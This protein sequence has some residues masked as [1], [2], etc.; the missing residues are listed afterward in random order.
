[1]NAV[2]TPFCW[3]DLQAV[4]T[5]GWTGSCSRSSNR[6][7][8]CGRWTGWCRSSSASA[9]WSRA[10]STSSRSSRPAG[11]GGGRLHLRGGHPGPAASRSGRGITPSTWGFAGTDG[12]RELDQARSRDRAREPGGGAGAADRHRLHPHRPGRFAPPLRRSRPGLRLPGQALYPPRAGG[13]G[14]TR[15]SHLPA[16][17]LRRRAA[18]S[19]RSVRRRRG[20]RPRSRWTATSSTI[21]SW[22]RRSGSIDLAEAIDR[23]RRR[24]QGMRDAKAF[25]AA[26]TGAAAEAKPPDGLGG[27]LRALWHLARDEW[28]R[29]ITLPR[30][31]EAGTGPGCTPICTGWRAISRTR[32][33]GTGGRIARPR[34]PPRRRMGGDRGRPPRASRRR[35]P[36]IRHRP[37]APSACG[38]TPSPARSRA[39][40]PRRRVVRRKGRLPTMAGGPAPRSGAANVPWPT[41]PGSAYLFPLR[42]WIRRGMGRLLGARASCPR[43]LGFGF[44]AR[45]LPRG[46]GAR[47]TPRT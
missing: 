28:M 1:M 31:T 17:R 11:G 41:L 8:T 38:Q 29:P 24:R 10:P 47:T 7:R 16:R 42:W 2:D 4:V 25:K 33:T 39:S 34:K 19:R 43:G 15:R 37:I 18:T 5:P 14:G 35:G 45:R 46:R 20:A 22:R 36:L 13:A 23:R 6:L 9:T 3:G 12:E 26:A 44:A 40:P 27:A 30:A 21:P 32:A